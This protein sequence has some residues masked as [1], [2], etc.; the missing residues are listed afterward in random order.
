MLVYSQDS[1][2][3]LEEA[4][5]FYVSIKNVLAEKANRIILVRHKADLQDSSISEEEALKMFNNEVQLQ[6]VTSNSKPET[7]EEAFQAL[8]RQ[9]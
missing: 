2:S 4:H 1:R 3:S 9:F 6:C 8:I 7:I 5:K